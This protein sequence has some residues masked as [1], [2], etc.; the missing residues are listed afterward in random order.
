MKT[1]LYVDLGIDL[2]LLKQGFRNG[3]P[4]GGATADGQRRRPFAARVSPLLANLWLVVGP[5]ESSTAGRGAD[6]MRERR[7][8]ARPERH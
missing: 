4:A 6:L 3:D 8:H 2:S 7:T 5:F 1:V